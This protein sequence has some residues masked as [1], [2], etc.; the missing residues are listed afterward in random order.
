MCA[1]GRLP[2]ALAPHPLAFDALPPPPSFCP[3]PLVRCAPGNMEKSKSDLRKLERNEHDTYAQNREGITAELRVR[4]WKV[5]F[6]SCSSSACF[7]RFAASGF[8]MSSCA[9]AR[10][11]ASS[12]SVRSWGHAKIKIPCRSVG[13]KLTRYA[14]TELKD[15]RTYQNVMQRKEEGARRKQS[16]RHILSSTQNYRFTA[17]VYC[18]FPFMVH[19]SPDFVL[20]ISLH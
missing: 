17:Q 19:L 2:S 6:C 7:C 11:S 9:L 5:T 16:T 18:T 20:P 4:S 12:G 14:C 3:P 1:P 8:F 10:V 13:E 15:P